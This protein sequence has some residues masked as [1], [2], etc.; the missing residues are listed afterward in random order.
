MTPSW[1][2]IKLLQMKRSEARR[3]SAG[4]WRK[5]ILEETAEAEEFDS[6]EPSADHADVEKAGRPRRTNFQ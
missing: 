3:W 6:A 1:Q 2:A 5:S 4:S